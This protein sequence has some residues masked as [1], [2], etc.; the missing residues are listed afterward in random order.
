MSAMID[1]SN[2]PRPETP[3]PWGITHPGPNG[4]AIA[5]L[6]D[7]I[8]ACDEKDAEI[9]RLR[10]RLEQIANYCEII[11]DGKADPLTLRLIAIEAMAVAP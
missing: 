2:L 6:P 9:A 8:A 4:A 10:R 1:T 11:P 7:W 5:A 3:G